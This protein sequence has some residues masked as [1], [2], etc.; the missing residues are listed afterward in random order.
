MGYFATLKQTLQLVMRSRRVLLFQFFGNVV[1]FLAF[2]VWLRIPE[3]HVS[4]LILSLIVFLLIA[5]ATLL[6]HGGTLNYFIGAHTD[7]PASLTGAF[8]KTLMHLFAFALWALL[9]YLLWA[10][11]HW[12]DNYQYSFPSYVR[13]ELPAW[14]RRHTSDNQFSGFYGLFV[15][16]LGGLIVPGLALPF[17][18]LAAERGFRGL[19]DARAWRKIVFKASYWT[20]L[21]FVNFCWYCVNELMELRLSG[22]NPTL[23]GESVS[24][25][26]RLGFAYLVGLLGWLLLCSVLGKTRATTSGEAAA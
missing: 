22:K 5:A 13:S 15:W 1:I 8:F 9:F 18:L 14:L 4:D 3:A 11:I 23:A 25:V 19:F 6:L 7:P 24:L 26:L 21:L 16:L 12:L 2:L 10:G 17:G 20:V